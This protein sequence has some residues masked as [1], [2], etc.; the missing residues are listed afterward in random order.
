MDK[1]KEDVKKNG[2]I[3]NLGFYIKKRYITEQDE[4]KLRIK[5]IP[6]NFMLRSSNFYEKLLDGKVKG[7]EVIDDD[8]IFISR[9]PRLRIK[10]YG[11]DKVSKEEFKDA[12]SI[13]MCDNSLVSL[14]DMMEVTKVTYDKLE[15]T[16]L[17]EGDTSYFNEYYG[18]FVIFHKNGMVRI[19]AVMFLA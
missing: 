6:D 2:G 12:I 15:N 7:S 4:G 5:V 13:L 19:E 18:I 3:N 14:A 8:T 10:I 11:M 16:N 1:C 17:D 9:L